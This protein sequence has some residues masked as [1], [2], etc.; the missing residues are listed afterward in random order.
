[1]GW[2]DG[3]GWW[4]LLVGYVNAPIRASMYTADPVHSSIEFSMLGA[5]QGCLM[6]MLLID[7]SSRVVEGILLFTWPLPFAPQLLSAQHPLK[8]AYQPTK[9]EDEHISPPTPE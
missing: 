6:T 1:M 3:E 8:A 2:E 5:R 4:C 9:Q 7:L